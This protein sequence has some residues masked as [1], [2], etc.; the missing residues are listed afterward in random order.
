MQVIYGVK[1]QP[2]FHL[3]WK[4]RKSIFFEE[5]RDYVDELL[6]SDLVSDGVYSDRGTHKRKNTVQKDTSGM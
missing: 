1:D 2:G 3:Y 4:S 6:T 5:Y